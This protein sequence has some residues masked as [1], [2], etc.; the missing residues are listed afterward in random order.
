MMSFELAPNLARFS[1]S[2][3]LNTYSI[4]A[5]FPET[6]STQTPCIS[7]QVVLEYEYT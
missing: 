5:D 7:K 6:L 3:N 1:R 2:T 4:V